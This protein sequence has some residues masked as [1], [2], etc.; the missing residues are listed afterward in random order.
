MQVTTELAGPDYG[1]CSRPQPSTH[2]RTECEAASYGPA[3]MACI[4]QTHYTICQMVRVTFQVLDT[5]FKLHLLNHHVVLEGSSFAP[6]RKAARYV[7]GENRSAQCPDAP[8]AAF[9]YRCCQAEAQQAWPSAWAALT[10]RRERRVY[11]LCF[12]TNA[13]ASSPPSATSIPVILSPSP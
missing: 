9:V 13:S 6:M 8:A 11:S 5:P 3:H 12:S 4:L 10:S 2:C 1:F 7:D